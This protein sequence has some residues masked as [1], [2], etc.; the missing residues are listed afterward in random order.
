MLQNNN[1]STIKKLS[2]KVLRENKMRN[3]FAIMAIALTTLLITTTITAGTTLYTTSQKYNMISS[4]G[5]DADG[6]IIGNKKTLDKLYSHENVDKVGIEQFASKGKLKNKELLNEGVYLDAGINKEVIEMMAI[7]PI[8]GKLPKTSNEVFMP[9][10]VLEILGVD[11]KVGENI[12]LDVVVDDKV[13]TI[14]FKLSGYY[15][16]LVSRGSGRTRVFVSDDFIDKYNKDILKEKNSRSAFVILKN[17]DKDSSYKDVENKLK[18]VTKDI[19]ASKYK[20][21]PKYDDAVTS[22]SDKTAFITSAVAGILLVIFTGYLIIYNIFYISVNRDI[23]L[24]GLLKTIGTTSKQLRKIIIKQALTLSLVGIPIG[25]LLGH[26][27]S[28]LLVPLAFRFTIFGNIVVVS[29]NIYV[30]IVSIL[31]SLATV[32]ISCRKPGKVAGKVSPI[33]AV[34]YV[35]SDSD[36][37]KSKKK[38]KKGVHGAKIHKM[39]WSNL[40]KNKKRVILSILSI[41]LSAL[42]VIFTINASLGMDPEKHAD[43]QMNYDISITNSDFYDSEKYV[44]ITQHFINNLKL[45]DFVD[46]VDLVH[47]AIVPTIGGNMYNFGVDIHLDGKLKK[48]ID[49]Q[50]NID[51]YKGY[52]EY[53]KSGN[54]NPNGKADFINTGV[55]AIERE[56]LDERL[57]NA[58]VIDGKVDSLDFMGD[59]SLIYYTKAGKSDFIKAGEK[60]PVTF[61]MRDTK[62]NVENVTKEFNVIAVVEDADKES[63]GIDLAMFNINENTFKNIFKKYDDSISRIDIKLK[64]NA[65]IKY[66]DKAIEK[67]VLDTGNSGLKYLS[68]N[69]YIESLIEFK[70]I[71]MI[72]G[73]SISAVLGTIGAINIINTVF[74]GIFARRVE[75]A[76]LESIGMTKKQLRQMVT[77]EGLYYILFSMIFI[78]PLGALV[79]YLAPMALPIYSGFNIKLYLISVSICFI[80]ISILMLS[81]PV[82]GYKIVSKDGIVER[83]RISE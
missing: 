5:I 11:K 25:L 66:A 17:V 15:E 23:R 41:T 30:F 52:N 1:K 35:S 72:I 50:Q 14:G 10:W 4:Y 6:Y 39:A 19:G 47:E 53:T 16:S 76:M 71:L 75:F 29:P 67:L 37:K 70:V 34:K 28:K 42:I 9:T 3:I 59:N 61:I 8:E 65:N 69:Y 13:K 58:K 82:I 20:V 57:K 45:S 31:F 12:N 40:F 38:S 60:L 73:L 79:A 56:R 63:S 80:V 74:T 51:G 68:K 2:N 44:P 55:Q 33:E 24:Y 78:I 49:S 62:G 7:V 27:L 36:S 83:L 64:D 18:E 54:G 22:S 26:L 46:Y 48:E 43:K 81:V 77:F 21:H 32:F